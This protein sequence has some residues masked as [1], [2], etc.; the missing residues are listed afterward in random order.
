MA[1]L[2]SVIQSITKGKQIY[3]TIDTSA[4]PPITTIVT[5]LGV[6]ELQGVIYQYEDG[7]ETWNILN[8]F[9]K[10]TWE[11]EVTTNN[12]IPNYRFNLP[13]NKWLVYTFVYNESA[14]KTVHWGIVEHNDLEH[15]MTDSSNYLSYN[16]QTLYISDGGCME[17]LP[18]NF[19]HQGEL[20]IGLGTIN[21]PF[22][23][24]R[25]WGFSGFYSVADLGIETVDDE[26][27]EESEEDGYE[28]G[29]FDDESD[30]IE[31]PD[32]PP[33]NISEMGYLNIYKVNE[34]GLTGMIDELFPSLDNPVFPTPTG[35]GT[36][37]DIADGVISTGNALVNF[38]INFANS[39]ILQYVIDTHIIPVTPTTSGSE[40]IKVGFR[41]L[42]ATGK[43]VSK[44]YVD[45]DCGTISV[46]EY[47]SNFVDYMGTV[48]NLY[49]PFVGFVPIKPEFFQNGNLQVKY[50]FNI[51]DGSFVAC[52][53]STSSKSKLS[54]TVVG[55]YSGNCCVHMP[56]RSND[57][58]SM[59]SGLVSGLSSI[60]G[61]MTEAKKGNVSTLQGL[62][63]TT[64]AIASMGANSLYSMSNGFNATSSYCGVRV[65]YL[66][67]SRQ[68]SNFSG[69][70]PQENGLP[71][72][73]KKK[74]SEVSGFTVCDNPHIDGI[75]C[76]ENERKQIEQLLKTG[77]I[78]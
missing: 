59:V 11:I 38:C 61:T 64:S 62:D 18:I 5:G 3:P 29:S 17:L 26:Y 14:L 70:Y 72:N 42:T 4:L 7:V 41:T 47:Y 39:N 58:A 13:N 10:P 23:G 77:I 60:G 35:D 27:G 21:Y 57:Y 48:A 8:D 24:G 65:P 69:N 67:I 31:F 2:E 50:K 68:V 16:A 76:T 20:Y 36:L 37:K 52:V 66:M 78:L 6:R 45:F 73:V 32:D 22:G 63:A 44:D 40:N 30:I 19:L 43:K 53:I 49:L 55:S 46:K 12:A 33:F 51:I 25:V 34:N 15:D 28:D 9:I 75:E 71:L 56:I 54:N 74:L 1:I